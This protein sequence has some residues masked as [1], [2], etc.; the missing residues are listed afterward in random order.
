MAYNLP[1]IEPMGTPMAQSTEVAQIGGIDSPAPQLIQGIQLESPN[2]EEELRTRDTLEGLL[3]LGAK[4]LSPLIEEKKK[5]AFFD[6]VSRAAKG[7]A[8]KEIVNEQPAWTRIFGLSASAQGAQQMTAINSINDITNGIMEQMPELRKLSGDEFTKHVFTAL[9]K[10]YSGDLGT[11]QII[12]NKM[13]ENLSTLQSHHTKESVRYIQER[14]KQEHRNGISIAAKGYRDLVSR[15]RAGESAISDTDI[16]KAQ[17]SVLNALTPL[18]GMEQG[19]WSD[20]VKDAYAELLATGDF[21]TTNLM[22]S[23]E[24]FKALSGEEQLELVSKRDTAEKRWHETIKVSELYPVIAGIHAEASLAGKNPDDLITAMAVVNRDASLK[25]GFTLP[26]MGSTEQEA[27]LKANYGTLLHK[28]EKAIAEAKAA[29]EKEVLRQLKADVLSHSLTS[30]QGI[31]SL[32]SVVTNEEFYNYSYDAIRPIY[33][34]N[35]IEGATMIANLHTRDPANLSPKF[36]SMARA[37]LQGTQGDKQNPLF[38]ESVRLFSALTHPDVPN[39]DA[40]ARTLFGDEGYIKMTKYAQVLSNTG[41]SNIAYA[42]TNSPS[43]VSPTDKR[44]INTVKQFASALE[45]EDT[46]FKYLTDSQRTVFATYAKPWVSRVSPDD[47]NPTKAILH[48]LTGKVEALGGYFAHTSQS[49]PTLQTALKSTSAQLTGEVFTATLTKALTDRGVVKGVGLWRRLTTGA[50]FSK[51]PDTFKELDLQ[52]VR[53]NTKDP[54]YIVRYSNPENFAEEYFTIKFAD[55]QAMDK[56]LTLERQK[57]VDAIQ[58][59][60]EQQLDYLVPKSAVEKLLKR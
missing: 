36:R 25:Y 22:Q 28:K 42:A 35:P 5:Q 57:E 1:T 15:R 41:D 4:V 56:E 21:H 3:D 23:A 44:E 20:N 52:I 37:G 49:L 14:S 12:Q 50:T 30:G 2:N 55:L 43:V 48:A 6:G 10:G 38:H 18:A 39:G 51:Y 40:A 29:G 17:V 11:D 19:A 45:D 47:P 24:V 8:V 9:E 54:S 32:G 7:V 34:K 16:D 27:I 59:R 46:A 13:I 58:K 60:K 31:L 53:A 33:N 26:V